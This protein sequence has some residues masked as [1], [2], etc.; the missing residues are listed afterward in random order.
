MPIAPAS[1]LAPLTLVYVFLGF[2]LLVLCLATR[3][4]W[5]VKALMVLLVSG[6]YFVGQHSF[7]L[8]SGWPTTDDLPRRF[9][10]LSAVFDEPNPARGH[11]GAIFIWVNPIEDNQPLSMPRVHQLP[12]EPDLR[13]ILGDGIKKARDGNTQIGTTE[14][15]RGGSGLPWLRPGSD[16]QVEIKLSDIPRAQLPEK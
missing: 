5:W 8:V 16:T 7:W 13:R 11:K 14:P 15:R 6:F 12:Y 1:A 3:W 2:A 9:V 4:R 10:L